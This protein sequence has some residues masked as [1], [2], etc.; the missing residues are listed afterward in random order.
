MAQMSSLF[1]CGGKR[2]ATLKLSSSSQNTRGLTFPLV[3]SRLRG[4]VSAALRLPRGGS[5]IRGTIFI[6]VGREVRF[7][8]RTVEYAVPIK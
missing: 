6:A 8:C 4:A 5:L 3:T 7:F 2:G 1:E